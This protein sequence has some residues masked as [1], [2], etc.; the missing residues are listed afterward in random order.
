MR[1]AGI[2]VFVDYDLYLDYRYRSFFEDPEYRARFTLLD[3]I[4]FTKNDRSGDGLGIYA[5]K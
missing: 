1:D 4:S 3:R 5:F 2:T